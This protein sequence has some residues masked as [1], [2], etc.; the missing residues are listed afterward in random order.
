MGEKKNIVFDRNNIFEVVAE[1]CRA[2]RERVGML[3]LSSFTKHD[4]TGPD[5]E[6]F[7]NR[8]VR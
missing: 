7:L 2:V 1:E 6:A 3:D 4:V 5:A 8:V